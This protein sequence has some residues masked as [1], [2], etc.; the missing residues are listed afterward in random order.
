[1]KQDWDDF[2]GGLESKKGLLSR[3]LSFYRINIIA[4][5]VNYY[6]N[7]YF[8][9][10]GF[11]VECGAGT[12]E[13]TLKTKKCNR[14]FF[15]V[16]Y[17]FLVLKKTVLNP[18]IDNC[19]NADIFLLPFPDGS[20]DGIWNVG[21]MEHFSMEDIDK[22]LSEFYR[23]L[24]PGKK[25][26]LFWPMAYAPYEIFLN[27]VEGI[28]NF[29]TKKDFHLYPGEISRLKSKRQG[30]EA[31]L[32]NKFRDVELFFNYRDAFSFGVAIGSK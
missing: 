14:H 16:D 1:M 13:T 4:G 15:A 9:D 20:I 5:S 32:K 8:D 30:R 7:K 12:S 18:K 21:V 28:Y 26:I 3:F 17:S 23:V 29:F 10:N 25:I 2:W 24:K 11:Y 6:I 19:I 22:I 27:I 31:L